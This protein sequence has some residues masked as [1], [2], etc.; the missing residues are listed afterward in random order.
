MT[1]PNPGQK[2]VFD[3]EKLIAFQKSLTL[4]QL[5]SWL[6]SNPPRKT[7]SVIDHLDRALSSVLL[8]MAEGY[9]KEAGSKDR[10]RFYRTAL[11]SAKEA[12]ACLIILEARGFLTRALQDKARGLLWEVVAML[13]VMAR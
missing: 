7:A 11:G 8:N 4:L 2:N 6:L 12:G 3:F 13:S 9:G 5:L 1:N 10:K